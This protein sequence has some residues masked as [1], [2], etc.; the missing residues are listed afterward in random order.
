M[1]SRTRIPSPT[2][3]FITRTASATSTVARTTDGLPVSHGGLS[4]DHPDKVENA[5]Y[6]PEGDPEDLNFSIMDA[7]L[8]RGGN[9]G[10]GTAFTLNELSVDSNHD[11]DDDTWQSHAHKKADGTGKSDWDTIRDSRFPA[12]VPDGL[13]VDAPP[14][15][16]TVNFA[17]VVG[18]GLTAM[19]VLD[20]G[21]SVGVSGL[22]NAKAGAMQF[23][24]DVDYPDTSFGVVSYDC[25]PA[26]ELSLGDESDLDEAFDVINSI[27]SYPR[28]FSNMW[29][30]LVTALGEITDQPQRA[31][32]EV[33]ILFS[34]GKHTFPT[35]PDPGGVTPEPESLIPQLIEEGITVI[36]VGVASFIYPWDEQRLRNIATQTGGE[37]V[38]FDDSSEWYE[39]L[40]LLQLAVENSAYAPVHRSPQSIASG[41]TRETEVMLETDATRGTFVITNSDP[42]DQL[43]ISLV[44]PSGVAISPSDAAIDPNIDFIS[45]S[46]RQ[47]LRIAN[48]EAGL[49]K[50]ITTA[51]TISTGEID[52]LA[53][54]KNDGVWLNASVV[55]DTLTHPESVVIQATPQ[56]RGENVVGAIVTGTATRPDGSIVPIAL[57]DDG[58]SSHGDEI[59]GDGV[60]SANFNNY[61]SNGNGTYSF[62]LTV[63]NSIGTTHDGEAL[64]A[65]AGAPSNAAPVPPFIRLATTTTVV[66]GVPVELPPV[67]EAGGP[68]IV[69]EGGS[70]RLSAAGSSDPD[71]HALTYQWDLD[72]NGTFESFGVAPL[73]SATGLDGPGNATVVLRVSDGDLFDI[74]VATV[75]IENVD[76]V[77]VDFSSDATFEN[78]AEE[79]ET[80][81][82]LAKF[83]D[84]GMLDTHVAEVDWGDGEIELVTVNQGVM[85]GT[86]TGRHEYTSG[87]IYT[88]TVTLT[89]DDTGTATADTTAVVTGVG[90]NDGVLYL[91]GTSG[92]DGVSINGFKKEFLK[93]H[94]TFIPDDFRTFH[95]ADVGKI[96]AYLCEGDD[97]FEIS[98]H[99]ATP[100]II[101]A[102]A[103]DDFVGAGAGPAVLLGDQGNDTLIGNAHRS[104]LI[105]GLG[106][107]RLIG[108][109]DEDVLIGGTTAQDQDDNALMA[110]LAAWNSS[111]VYSDRVAAIDA[112]VAV[113]DDQENDKL[114]GSSGRDLW[115]AGLTDDL[116]DISWI[117]PLET[118]L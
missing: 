72:N 26:V 43:A 30:G 98:R 25:C 100:V 32:D 37:Y 58:L 3:T 103:G 4:W 48:P 56:Y 10:A 54:A 61:S 53:F 6:A 79:G 47:S 40:E 73:F 55:K 87:G 1:P 52:V 15:P 89:D 36:T 76:P 110:A 9:F 7:F 94:A 106:R 24:F 70:V 19:V 16:H 42:T 14:A 74:D 41:E 75:N 23:F 118:V 88:I 62:D 50:I 18:G 20:I 44:S 117:N 111:D 22:Q 60:Y 49:W 107:D 104:I 101:H 64:F 115:F 8:S 57:F 28:P 51:E 45:S 85:S 109:K 2:N 35:Y 105:G 13:P 90:L 77:I 92:N 39:R 84:V 63:E 71:G 17:D 46:N 83:T 91:I 81:N 69:D 102:G 99:V 96:V 112:L 5:P 97:E 113:H 114:T 29:G 68:Y 34:S 27:E 31:G 82:V 11:P 67:A 116:T 86:V 93:V 78:K 33:I 59:P 108:G 95:T 21:N 65:H 66:S 38:R 80:V 12:T